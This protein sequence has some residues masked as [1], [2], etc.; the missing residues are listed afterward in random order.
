MPEIGELFYTKFPD[1]QLASQSLKAQLA[2]KQ[3]HPH[4]M[5]FHS[6]GANHPGASL[7]GPG[8]KTAQAPQSVEQVGLVMI[9][10]YV[11][12]KWELKKD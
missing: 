12:K 1:H 10:Q 6:E 11:V 5:W 9:R 3:P 4:L 8:G 7:P 2:D